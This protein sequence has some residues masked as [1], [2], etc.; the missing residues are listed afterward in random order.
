MSWT[1]YLKWVRLILNI[2]TTMRQCSWVGLYSIQEE[3]D[4]ED[5]G[6]ILF[7]EQFARE[8][9]PTGYCLEKYLSFGDFPV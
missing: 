8:T 6:R 3:K 9:L 5:E 4:E 2:N 7:R 1:H